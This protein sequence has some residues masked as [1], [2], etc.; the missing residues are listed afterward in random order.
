MGFPDQQISWSVP[1]I[2]WIMV[3]AIELC[4]EKVYSDHDSYTWRDVRALL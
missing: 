1:L 4:R 2:M 3:E